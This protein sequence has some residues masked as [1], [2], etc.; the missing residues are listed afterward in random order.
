MLCSHH[1][2]APIFCDSLVDS[3][4]SFSDF[5][6]RYDLNFWSDWNSSIRALAGCEGPGRW[7]L[8]H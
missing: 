7:R 4:A 5:R 3:N 2:V 6:F 8:L 1:F